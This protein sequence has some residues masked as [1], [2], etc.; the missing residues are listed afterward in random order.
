M[1]NQVSSAMVFVKRTTEKMPFK[2]LERTIPKGGYRAGLIIHL[3][4]QLRS[5]QRN[6][7]PAGPCIGLDWLCWKCAQEGQ[8]IIIN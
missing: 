6:R 8:L 4:M 1:R 2:L 3:E 7:K 5:Q